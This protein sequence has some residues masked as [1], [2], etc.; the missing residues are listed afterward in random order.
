MPTS[1]AP[2]ASVHLTPPHSL[3]S[4]P[5]HKTPHTCTLLPKTPARRCVIG[6]HATRFVSTSSPTDRWQQLHS[7]RR[8]P[9]DRKTNHYAAPSPKHHRLPASKATT[10]RHD[11]VPMQALIE[12][13]VTHTGTAA[14]RHRTHHHFPPL[15]RAPN[16]KNNSLDER[17]NSDVHVQF[18]NRTRHVR[19]SPIYRTQSE[20]TVLGV[21]VAK[22][23]VRSWSIYYTSTYLPWSRQREYQCDCDAVGHVTRPYTIRANPSCYTPLASRVHAANLRP[24]HASSSFT[25]SL[26]HA[27]HSIHESNTPLISSQLHID[28]AA[29]AT[30]TDHLPS[31]PS[32]TLNKRK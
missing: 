8:K 13:G 19:G 1:G 31:L 27:Q 3:P 25:S 4:R 22:V 18:K 2:R 7:H 29:T 30:V 26:A 14:P 21:E 16:H 9:R 5:R 24:S 10:S 32:L 28:I 12:R 15:I 11:A 23:G 17:P 20:K 6:N